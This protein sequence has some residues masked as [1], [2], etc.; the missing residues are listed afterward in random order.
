M[1]MEKNYVKTDLLFSI[2]F[3]SDRIPSTFSDNVFEIFFIIIQVYG[4]FVCLFIFFLF[5]DQ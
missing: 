4:G 5:L 1:N 3:L 2:R